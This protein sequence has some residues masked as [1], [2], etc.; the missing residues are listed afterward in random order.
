MPKFDQPTEGGGQ[1]SQILRGGSCPDFTI[2]NRKFHPPSVMFSEWFIPGG[3]TSSNFR[4]PGTAHE[5]KMDPIGSKLFKNE[6]SKK[7]KLMEK[8]VNWIENEG[9]IDTKCLKSVK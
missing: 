2:K 3:G 1:I 9:K 8:G 7:F 5:N 6:G 4:Y